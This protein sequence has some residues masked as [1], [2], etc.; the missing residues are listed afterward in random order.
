ARTGLGARRTRHP[1]PSDR[2]G[3]ATSRARTDSG[4]RLAGG[5][6]NGNMNE[7]AP[8]LLGLEWFPDR[9]GGLQRYFRELRQALGDPPAVVIGPV[10]DAPTGLY[11]PASVD[12][13]L[14]RRLVRF[15][16]QAAEL[17]PDADVVDAHFALYAF[18]ALTAGATRRLPLVVHFQGPW[19]EESRLAG[20]PS[21]FRAAVKR[22]IERTV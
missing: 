12:E 10:A 9:P 7:P 21:R 13:S 20:H 15:R 18:A 16:C 2:R 11:V 3:R 19:S 14:V 1:R 6:A 22:R 8:L 4:R 5:A 17:A